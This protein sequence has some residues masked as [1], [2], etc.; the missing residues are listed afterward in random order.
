MNKTE[1]DA[2]HKRMAILAFLSHFLKPNDL[3]S[4]E[5]IDNWSPKLGEPLAKTCEKLERAGFLR[6]GTL[7][8]KISHRFNGT[9]LKQF[10]KD[11]G[12][13]ISGKKSLQAERLA[14]ADSA[15]FAPDLNSYRVFVCTEKGFAITTAFMDMEKAR[16]QQAC[17]EILKCLGAGDIDGAI[18]YLQN[19]DSLNVFHLYPEESTDFTTIA[20]LA[21]LA[22]DA[23]WPGLM[24]LPSSVVD[25]LRLSTAMRKI[26]RQANPENWIS[27]D[28]PIL[29]KHRLEDD[30]SSMVTFVRCELISDQFEKQGFSTA[31]FLPRNPTC[32]SCIKRS[33]LITTIIP[34]EL[35]PWR[36]CTN[37]KL[38]AWYLNIELEDLNVKPFTPNQNW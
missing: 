38:C 7:A 13:L 10:L 37:R 21:K 29:E 2:A 18:S 16:E 15:T 11:R 34:K 26:W 27:E 6:T 20:A 12:L 31:D 4:F 8:E 32:E 35:R 19:W 30:L 17:N 33:N 36:L 23:G 25:Q 14:E 5:E 1:S 28:F 3:D 24:G 22:L 9:Q